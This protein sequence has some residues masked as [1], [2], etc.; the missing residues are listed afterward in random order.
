MPDREQLRAVQAPI[1][2]SDRKE[3]AEALVTLRARGRTWRR[4][5]LQGRD[6]SRDR[7]SG[8]HPATGGDGL[9]LCSGDMLLEALVACAG[10]TLGA[11]ATALGIDVRAGTVRAEGDLDFRGTLGVARTR[12]SASGIRLASSSTPTRRT[13]SSRRCFELTERYCVV[14]QTIAA[15]PAPTATLTRAS[16]Q[17][18]ERKRSSAG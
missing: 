7:R 11:V 10:V 1:K 16:P 8:L 5:H 12:R 6:R 17:R 9:R 13:S 4:R 18:D 3:P 2:Q 15:G 14:L